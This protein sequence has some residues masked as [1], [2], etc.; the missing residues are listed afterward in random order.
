MKV[1][2]VNLTGATAAGTGRSQESLKAESAGGASS[3]G[4]SGGT[5]GPADQVEFSSTLGRLSR[6]MSAY[7][8]ARSERVAGLAAA[9]QS[10]SYRVDS[11][12]T[13]RGMIAEALAGG[14]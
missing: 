3:G 10:G 14:K 7:G 12:A 1:Y 6:A 2:D 5:Q 9:Y 4:K 8:S 13:S 11:R